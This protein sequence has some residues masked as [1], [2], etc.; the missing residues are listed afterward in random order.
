MNPVIENETLRLILVLLGNL[1]RYFLFA[2][3]A[4]LLFYVWKR[5]AWLYM[6][7]QQKFP[8]QHDLRREIGYS[9]STILIFA[10]FAMIIWYARSA[11]YT[12]MYTQVDQYG[13]V[14]WV[15]SLGLLI[16]IHDTWFYWTHR[17]MHS[18]PRIFRLFHRVH[19]LSH[20]PTPWTAFAFHPAEAIVEALFFPLVVFLLPL[21]LG[22]LALFLLWMIVLNVI[23]HTG[24]EIIPVK[25]HHTWIGRIQNTPTHHNMHH[26]YGRGNYSLYFNFWDRWMGT[27]NPNYE[28]EYEKNAIKRQTESVEMKLNKRHKMGRGK[29]LHIHRQ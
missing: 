6:K 11:G 20:N 12:R 22:V 29:K 13:W 9:L 4:Y 15:F 23:G 1:V 27:N 19:H 21:H 18:S 3:M 14:Y 26:H 28:E 2:G 17:W 5:K 16:F 24:Y 8:T 7:I 10:V 25:Y